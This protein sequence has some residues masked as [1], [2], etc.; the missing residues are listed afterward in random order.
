MLLFIQPQ[1][2]EILAAGVQY[3]RTEG[4]FYALI[5]LLFLLYGFYRAIER[6]AMS[7]VLTVIS[8]G[9][10][11]ILAYSLSALPALGV[12]GIWISIPIGW[13]LAD[14][15]GCIPMA[16]FFR[17]LPRQEDSAP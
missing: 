5:A 7:V 2:T 8:L 6:P 13:A 9:L 14:I 4:V 1:E 16:K 15:A 10:R 17:S 12:M 11:V 3:L